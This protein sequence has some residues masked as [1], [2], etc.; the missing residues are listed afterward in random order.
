MGE[1][2]GRYRGSRQTQDG[3]VDPTWAPEHPGEE[4]SSFSLAQSAS[5]STFDNRWR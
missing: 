5:Q 1:E 3:K 2:G 4:V